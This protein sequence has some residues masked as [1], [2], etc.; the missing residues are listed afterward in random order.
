MSTV[1]RLRDLTITRISIASLGHGSF[2]DNAKCNG[3]GAKRLASLVGAAC[4][5]VARP[6]NGV[7]ATGHEYNGPLVA[8]PVQ[9]YTQ[10]EA[11]K[12][13]LGVG[14]YLGVNA[15]LPQKCSDRKIIGLFTTAERVLSAGLLG[16]Q[17][18]VSIS[19]PVDQLHVVSC[20][21]TEILPKCLLHEMYNL[22]RFN[23]SFPTLFSTSVTLVRVD[24]SLLEGVEVLRL[25]FLGV[26]SDS[27]ELG[28]L[29]DGGEWKTERQCS[30]V[31]R[32]GRVDCEGEVTDGCLL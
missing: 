18:T 1:R 6:C 7:R 20:L 25:V 2:T 13:R 22:V 32:E 21:W 27:D 30:P 28:A 8:F 10:Q 23:A 14:K 11:K 15:L 3:T 26:C 4:T 24:M 12:T 31:V 17:R 16:N 19:D 9:L 5:G 29:S